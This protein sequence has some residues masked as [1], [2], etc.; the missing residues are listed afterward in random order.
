M[1]AGI[2]YGA[3][4]L[5]GP[6]ATKTPPSGPTSPAV[7]STERSQLK[8]TAGPQTQL[9]VTVLAASTAD[10]DTLLVKALNVSQDLKVSGNVTIGG[11]ITA[12]G[13][14][15]S[16]SG[17]SGVDA[18]TLDGH[19]SSYFVPA[20]NLNTIL[21]Q[22]Q[23]PGDLA[24]TDQANTFSAANTFSGLLT[25]SG[26]LSVTGPASFTGG[27][28][29]NA[30]ALGS[31][32]SVPNGGTG[33]SN[34]TQ[35]GVLYGQGGGALGVAV[36]AG[37]GLCLMSGATDPI[38]GVCGGG[39]SGVASVNGQTG[40]LTIANATAGAGTITLNDAS[41][42]A[43][44]IAQF[45]ATNFSAAGGVVN[46]AQNIDA[47]A[48]P[49]F[50]GVNTNAV[51][52]SAA[53]TVG[54]IAQTLT[55]QGSTTVI[56]ANNGGS[57]T[58]LTFQ[59][60]TANVTYRL[61]TA[62]AGTYDVCTTAG[63]CV[64][65]GGGVTTPGGTTNTVPKFTGAQTLGNSL[66][67]DNGTLITVGGNLSV[68]GTANITGAVT[69]T[70]ALTV[71][72][73]GT[74]ATTAAGARTNLG[75]AASG[76]NGDI[77]SLTAL[78]AITPASALTVGATGQQFT[79]QGN[80]SS[81]I[82][83]TGGGFTTTVG[84]T[85]S[86][87]G[88]VVYQFDRAATAG[89]YTICST[90]GNCAGVGGGVTT[91]GGVTNN[92]A[93]FTGSN[94][95]DDSII[96]DNGS[97]V[98]I[99]G[100]LAVNTITPTGAFLAGATGQNLTL[101]GAA[102]SLTSTNGGTTNSLTFATASSGNKTITIPNASGTVAVSASG[103]I[104]LDAAGN[105]TCP[106]CA[107]TGSG[108]TQLNSLTGALTL[109]NATGAGAT[110]TID[111]ATTAA[112][113]IAS[114]NATNFSVAS[115]AVNTIQNI[116]SGASPTFT[117]LTLSGNLTVQGGTATVG[118]AA[119]QGSLVLHD[120]NGQTATIS[121]GSALAANT[122]LA[123]P[124]A[125]GS[126]DTFCLLTLANCVGTGGGVS[127]SGTN[128][129]IT[130]F[131]STGSTVGDSTIT[132]NGT[133][134]TTSVNLVVQ[135]GSGTLG[136]TSQ[137]GSLV[138][139]DGN[140]QTATISIGS[141][142]V[143]NTAI[144]I[145]TGV[146]A[147]DTVC[148]LTLAN[149]VG[150]G[151]G[152][153]GSGTINRVVKFTATGS[154]IGNS[155]FLDDG[156]SVTLDTNVNLLLQGATA[157]ISNPQGAAESEAFGATANVSGITNG[158]ALAVGY[159]AQSNNYGVAVGAHTIAQ[160][161]RDIAIGYNSYAN[162]GKA[163]AL[164][165][166]ANASNVY[167][168]ALGDCATTSADNQL[169]IGGDDT[170]CGG[171]GGSG[172]TQA[173]IGNGVTNAAPTSFTLQGTSGLGAN[174]AGAAVTIA[175]GQGTGSAAGGNVVIQ[176]AAAG[177]AGSS[178]NVLSTVATF[179]PTSVT[180]GTDVNL[181]LQGAN[182]HITNTQGQTAS[183]VFGAGASTTQD[184]A[185]VIGNSASTVVANSVIIG[186]G[187]KGNAGNGGIAIGQGAIVNSTNGV[188]IGVGSDAAFL[189]TS[190]GGGAS[191]QQES[192]AVGD[193]AV[194]GGQKSVAIGT[195]AA[196]NQNSSIAIGYGATTTAGNQ[197]VIGSNASPV[198]TAYIGNGVTNAS[199]SGF[200]LQG[201]SGV[202]TNVTGAGVTIAGGQGTGSGAGGDLSFQIAAPGATGSTLNALGTVFSVSG[203][204]GSVLFKNAVD[205]TTAF[206][207]QNSSTGNLF[208]VDTANS[209]VGVNLGV[210]GLPTLA[211]AG[212]QVQ[213]VF[214]LTG[215]GGHVAY[216]TPLGTNI[217][218]HFNIVN[219]DPGNNGQIIAAGISSPTANANARVISLF[220]NRNAGHQATLAVF[221]PDENGIV[222][223]NWDGS[224]TAA[225]VGTNNKT[226]SGGSTN[227]V[228][229]QSGNVAGGNGT[230]GNVQVN[231]GSIAGGS[232]GF[233]TGS[234]FVVTGDGGGTNA[235]SGS[236]SIDSGSKTGTGTTGAV[237]IGGT[238]ASALNLGRTGAA[239][240]LQGNAS[241]VI[242]ATNGSGTTTL[243]FTA[244]T[245]NV[246]LNFPALSAGTYS[247]C[248][249]SGNCS[250]V[251]ATLQT[252]YNNTGAATPEIV[253]DSTRGALTVRDNATP[254]TGNLLEVQ[255]NAGSTSY[256]AVTSAAVTL[257]SDVQLL[258]TG[259][260]AYISNPQSGTDTEV[261]GLNAHVNNG[262]QFAAAIGSNSNAATRSVALGDSADS[263]DSSVALGS[264]S[265][266][267]SGSIAIGYNSNAAVA[268]S[269]AI[270]VDSFTTASHQ[271]VIGSNS[272]SVTQVVIGNGVTTSGTPA[273]F[274]LQGTSAN[275]VA[276]TGGADVTIAGGQGT[277][278]AV[279]GSILFKSSLSGT[280]GG[281]SPNALS[282]L[283]TLST[284]SFTTG[285]DLDI[286]LQGT[287]AY[288]SN[289]Q[290]QTDA[291]AFG[292]GASVTGAS[293]VAV[294][295]GATAG[296]AGIGIGQGASADTGIAIGQNATQIGFGH[297]VAIGDSSFA[298]DFSVAVGE[299][300]RTDNDVNNGNGGSQYAVAL[301]NNAIAAFGSIA[302][303]YNA[304]TS[305]GKSIAIGI[306]AVA[307]SPYQLVIGA[308]NGNPFNDH[309]DQVVVGNGVTSTAP[310]GFT[311]QGTS[312]SG[313][314]VG[315]ASVAVAGGQGTG[316]G[317]GG[318]LNFQIAAPGGSGSSL[319]SLSTVASLSGADGSALF[320]NATDSATAFRV[321][322]AA[323]TTSALSVDTTGS[324]SV[325]IGGA[326]LVQGNLTLANTGSLR[327]QRA[328]DFSTTGT[329]NDANLGASSLVR[330]TGASAQTITGIAGGVDGRILT[331]VNAG[332]NNAVIS[333]QG[334]GS[335]ATNRIL[336]GTGA[337]INLLA[338]ASITL[339]YDSG[340]SR[341][342]VTGAA[343][344]TAGGS[345]INNS[346]V[347]QGGAN[348][349]IAGTGQAANFDAT[350][351]ALGLGNSV[352]TG[353]TIGN[354]TNTTSF[355]VQGA[356]AATYTIGTS[357][358]TGGITVGNST[359]NNTINI[360]NAN[361]SANTQTI[362]IGSGA[363][364]TGKDNVTIG[365]TNDGSTLNLKAGTGNINLL[366]SA[367]TTL[368]KST[369]TD[370]ASTFQIQNAAGTS[371]FN[372]STVHNAAD[373]VTNGSIEQNATGW[374]GRGSGSVSRVT[375]QQYVGAA[376]LQVGTSGS[377]D[378]AKY[379]VTLASSTQYSLQFWAKLSSGTFT[380]MNY[381][382]SNDGTTGGE[383]DCKTGETV[384][385][386]GWFVFNCTFTTGTV[387]G[388]P[389]FYM[390][391]TDGTARTVFLDA[392]QIVPGANVGAFQ[393]GK[394]NNGGLVYNQ[395]VAIQND[396]D[397]QAVFQIQSAN[398]TTVLGVDSINDRVGINL[399]Q[400]T[401]ALHV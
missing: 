202:G 97:T 75:A 338:D 325:T 99:G 287:N 286:L 27:A 28:S 394:I 237:T 391:Q 333:N 38:W 292:L 244:P 216:V 223:F 147:S 160:S 335:T 184:H 125:V 79:L 208:T 385:T 158:G 128:N 117:G 219:D 20:S 68:T 153:S 4:K 156:S 240:T 373:L 65:T 381:G 201:T 328:S 299:G 276:D 13:F 176:A 207:V 330:L 1:L 310:T 231:T 247:I 384:K 122:A 377:G 162:G 14:V 386:T 387:S 284:S 115:G 157:T 390:K 168:V 175:G 316:T 40:V 186:A 319:N 177:T 218:S 90:A 234:I 72:N 34:V 37:A 124:T 113:G 105:I 315:G 76:A 88:A 189:S 183:E 118:T 12:G 130:K 227:T 212:L 11:T 107:S 58:S 209:E 198:T 232:G 326:G 50:A 142:L 133:T 174:I 24:H 170:N 69:L 16:G 169:V 382:Y 111:N 308:D 59:A 180:L 235:S 264:S 291:E 83:A 191:T 47:A 329:T 331:I 249:S 67:T 193:G 123:I 36:P 256:L 297:N 42:A 359:A 230:S 96:S 293:A 255:N 144:A 54:A 221:S 200:V 388:T 178:L 265:Q 246:T 205:S 196:I 267:G 274:T 52:P 195:L 345:F 273:G 74:G 98:T 238:N 80:A 251:G 61:L 270:G 346:T 347:Q 132:D 137:Q 210:G 32:L 121:V 372:V 101:Q 187:A 285:T 282:T 152:V 161:S 85:G 66:I 46:T 138:L 363:S 364:G 6:Q 380:A 304:D 233:T 342:R 154:T 134:V 167:S 260:N 108:V 220:D 243:G 73:G 253:L 188:A 106:T 379:S 199:P 3:V 22:N 400:P 89:T 356:A 323:G 213:G 26:N 344:A 332:T 321:Q 317:N 71:G 8:D 131:T 358:N 17:L 145:P 241:S 294:G 185:V 182:A 355:L 217:P 305:V 173:V 318:N 7:T 87:T 172:I 396:T 39:G 103:L 393:E 307:T 362:N 288:I 44:G 70:T 197:L 252:A 272:N 324:T 33:L 262:A 258:L 214:Q 29:I 165:F 248:T 10:I 376:S 204:D 348:F 370:S 311:L 392:L 102:V 343:S 143:A 303:G 141:A 18:T 41:T 257:G 211:T 151:G 397:S 45:N 35:Q 365:S 95:I 77:T 164:G 166:S 371:L 399:I 2:G 139:H 367:A 271:M 225:T 378:G 62:A 300:A 60:P 349:N 114:F 120:G 57:V 261:F 229:L 296:L 275:A 100:T 327:T 53:L 64:G 313:A 354:T 81:T 290:G 320:K 289:P 56:T 351:G 350:S 357:N 301:G 51:T 92:L 283:A 84:F 136:T 206:N 295:A 110:I 25:A 322:N 94:S 236:I 21:A 245:A 224:S 309:I 250:G 63:N 78:T 239:F 401:A 49:T 281:S 361:V 306:G 19:P 203:A 155:S 215:T 352:A 263:G 254:I 374:S 194:V 43:K 112:K 91:P 360:G 395:P 383:V 93:K 337:D 366:T 86:P 127:G 222:G 109:A 150:T 334:A 30:L 228:I 280:G 146:G 242:K 341:W 119:Q 159:A 129:R 226:T 279:G 312:G 278:S 266:T 149:C 375:T 5:F 9:Q 190:V 369:T 126:S 104:A 179:S 192:V 48:T 298:S 148:L 15:G 171:A 314:N 55:L 398:G 181:I 135:G 163:L 368:I 277:G 302:I 31:A 389:Y 259:N 269:I 23:L 82:T 353:V 116:N 268:D 140:G 339:V 340:A 336:T